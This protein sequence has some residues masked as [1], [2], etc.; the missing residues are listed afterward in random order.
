M[1]IHGFEV[2]G[3]QVAFI[4]IAGVTLISAAMVVLLPNIL[5]AALFLGLALV[6]IAGMYVLLNAPFLAAAQIMVYVGGI[7]TMIILAI[8]LSHKVMEV[9]FTRATYN[10][11]L[12]AAA[13]G[14]LGLFLLVSVA[15]ST[16]LSR[17]AA[18]G[19]A[20]GVGTI[21]QIGQSLLQPYAFPFILASIILTAVI[22]V[23]AVI[24]KEDDSD[25]S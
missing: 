19:P 25:G 16:L 9:K 20:E 3:Y 15:A 13:S 17:S 8:F 12:A 22:V 6:G 1:N 14:V 21:E 18:P 23:V 2:T 7:T 10:P 11:L 4:V 5:R 24:A